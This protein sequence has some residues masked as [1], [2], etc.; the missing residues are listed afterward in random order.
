MRIKYPILV[1]STTY[2]W[3]PS[4][5]LFIISICSSCNR[6]EYV[7]NEHHDSYLDSVFK[8]AE[9]NNE[10]ASQIV[11]DAFRSINNPSIKDLYRKYFFMWNVYAEDKKDY[12]IAMRYADSTIDLMRE[13]TFNKEYVSFY[14][15][16]FFMK[17]DIYLAQKNYSEAFKYYYQGRE[18]ILNTADACAVT[19]YTNRMAMVMYRQKHYKEAIGYYR[20]SIEGH[21]SCDNINQRYRNEQ[22]NLNN[23]GLSYGKIGMNDS[24]LYY[25]NKGIYFIEKN[26]KYF[27]GEDFVETA[28]G[29]IYGNKADILFVRRQID[30][31]EMLYTESIRLNTQKNHDNRDAQFSQIK[32]AGLYLETGR[33]ME[34][35]QLLQG[36]RRSLD[37]LHNEAAE[38]RWWPMQKRYYDTTG[39]VDKAYTLF[40]KYEKLK[41]SITANIQ[42]SY[43]DVNKEFELIKQQYEFDL[44][45]KRSEVKT[46]YLVISVLFSIMAFIILVMAWNTRK[47]SLRKEKELIAAKERAEE[48]ARAKQQFL[49]NMSHEIRTPMN[50]VIGMTHLLLNEQPKPE[51]EESLRAL[52]FASE[53]LMILLNDILDYSKMDAGKMVL[54]ESVFNFKELVEQI[55]KSHEVCA[56]KKNIDCMVEVDPKIPNILIGD[57]LR[58]TQILNNLLSNA[59]KFTNEG[60]VKLTISLKESNEKNAKLL[61][62]ISDTG[63][64]IDAAQHASVFE[65]FTQAS[66]E[67]TRKFGGTG[68]GLAITK[69]LL[70]LMGSTITLTSEKDK[71][72]TFSFLLT[73]GKVQQQLTS[74]DSIPE[75]HAKNSTD[76]SVL[77][78]FKILVV[79]D[80]SMNILVVERVLSRWGAQ[81]ERALS[82][83]EAL[84]MLKQQTFDLILMDLQ[85][86]EMS[87]YEVTQHIRSSAEYHHTNTPIIALTADVMSET[88]SNAIAAGMNDYISKPFSPDELYRKLLYY[89]KVQV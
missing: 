62:T 26:R 49:S 16:G 42:L 82:G 80:N 63:I 18:V 39:Q 48:A 30:S 7:N 4:I 61:F 17:G 10:K 81:I 34:A 20:Q 64:G 70:Q 46:I 29:V 47:I 32:L 51:Q 78:R 58:L 15:R 9:N 11:N 86:P 66:S 60:W 45:K 54:E 14:A 88:R 12:R 24:A 77:S 85:M 33:F 1:H 44:V 31:A 35:N 74:S 8:Y 53:N 65:S 84:D 71:G 52:K 21:Y 13:N 22:R 3:V 89:L 69:R 83:R 23:I 5:V 67:T 19:E 40:Q 75:N 68:L 76:P 50:A 27:T 57:P 36:V 73:L 79:D 59:V 55:Q 38:L 2:L 72:S 28:L 37:T 56:R 43:F 41:D 6:Y 87:G 25:F